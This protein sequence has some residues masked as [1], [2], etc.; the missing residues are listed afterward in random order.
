MNLS[1]FD[2]E[3]DDNDVDIFDV[4]KSDPSP[5]TSEHFNEPE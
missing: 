2:P 4:D 3:D 1:N 5:D